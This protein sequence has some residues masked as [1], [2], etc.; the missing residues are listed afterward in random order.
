MNRIVLG[1]AKGAF[2]S[3]EALISQWK[4]LPPL[5]LV[6]LVVKKK[7]KHKKEKEGRGIRYGASDPRQR[8][9]T[10]SSGENSEKV[11]K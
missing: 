3:D 7:R 5:W 2:I 8:F 10:Q 11:G 6:S 1:M 9:S 4:F